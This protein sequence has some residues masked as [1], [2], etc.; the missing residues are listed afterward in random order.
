MLEWLKCVILGFAPEDAA[1][2][3]VFVAVPDMDFEEI[4]VV[5]P[6]PPSQFVGHFGEGFKKKGIVCGIHG[7]VATIACMVKTGVV[8]EIVVRPMREMRIS[9]R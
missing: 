2:A 3:S 7:G 5:L 4:P 1:E 8:G 9:L 6:S